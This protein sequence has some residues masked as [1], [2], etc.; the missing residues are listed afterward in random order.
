MHSRFFVAIALT[1]GAASAQTP[2]PENQTITVD[3]RRTTYEEIRKEAEEFVRATGVA[4]SNKAAARWVDAICPTVKGVSSANAAVVIAK[5]EAEARAAGASVARRPCKSNIIV[6]FAADGSA[7]TAAIA[8]DRRKVGDVPVRE[9]QALIEDDVPLRW[10]YA[11]DTRGRQGARKTTGQLPWVG[12]DEGG[13]TEGG[14][15]ALN[16][17]TTIVQTTSSIVSTQVNRVLTNATI[18][19]D[20]TL[21]KGQPLDAI[22]ANI[23]M[24][25]L[26][27][28]D[29]G[30][31]PSGS[32]L[33][34]F[35][36]P[37][38][39]LD[40][41]GEGDRALLKSLYAIKLDRAGWQQKGSLVDGM[42]RARGD[43][44]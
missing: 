25:A 17:A 6:A 7:L 20:A 24:V 30:A 35:A 19:V 23:A 21:A 44:E 41:L 39:G 22:A 32:I 13:S 28:I 5:I 8:K 38:S 36:T 40:D 31:K 4:T 11:T 26:A 18:I 16:E 3:G 15:S 37:S 9:R 2:Q 43:G 12:S 14:G 33:S 29:R 1:A 42:L 34:L 10:W 27:E